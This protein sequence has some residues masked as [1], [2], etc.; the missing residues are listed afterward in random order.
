M[1]VPIFL[2]ASAIV[3]GL[4]GPG[5]RPVLAAPQKALSLASDEDLKA[6]IEAF[7]K[8]YAV[9]EQNYADHLGP[10]K[11][12]YKGAI[13]GMLRTLD[14][15]SNFFDPKDF[16]DLREEQHGKY[17]GVGMTIGPQPRTGKTMVIHPFG[18]SPAYKAGLRPGDV[19]TEV[20]GKRVDTA[21]STEIASMLKGPR[22]TK[23]QVVV[24]REG[25]TKPI[26]FNLVRDE[27]PRNSV[28]DVFWLRPG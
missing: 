5:A 11:A 26:T 7:T 14:P 21:S 9:V 19:L 1:F 16:T 8:V 17:Y 27:I 10:D 6:N 2:G 22:G 4:F 15:H 23:V 24:N 25:T 12:I 3:G 18:G 13:P 28:E 20:N